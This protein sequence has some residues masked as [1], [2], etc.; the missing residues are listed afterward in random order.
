MFPCLSWYHCLSPVP[1]L[2]AVILKPIVHLNVLLQVE[3]EVAA[4]SPKTRATKM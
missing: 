1:N 2:N 4:P 3:V